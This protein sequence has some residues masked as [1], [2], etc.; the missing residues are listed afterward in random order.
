MLT[1]KYQLIYNA[2]SKVIILDIVAYEGQETNI[3][4][5]F[6]GVEF[7]GIEDKNQYIIDKD[8]IYEE[9]DYSAS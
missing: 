3:P 8:L 9:M 1:K 4:K 5:G 2:K 7:D 6:T